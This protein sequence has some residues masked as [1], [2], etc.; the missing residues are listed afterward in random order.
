M[1]RHVVGFS[2]V[3]S[4][5]GRFTGGSREGS[6]ALSGPWNAKP[7]AASK[8]AGLSVTRAR[9][10]QSSPTLPRSS[11]FTDRPQTRVTHTTRKSLV[12][13]VAGTWYS[14]KAGLGSEMSTSSSEIV[15]L[16]SA[17]GATGVAALGTAVI[18][19][20]AGVSCV[21]SSMGLLS[22]VAVGS[23]ATGTL[24][25][26]TSM[27]GGVWPDCV[28]GDAYRGGERHNVLVSEP[29][30]GNRSSSRDHAR[31]LLHPHNYRV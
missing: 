17:K 10:G 19:A 8:S 5:H 21:G 16:V 20:I 7:S 1:K 13:V 9:T 25:D 27:V 18:V 6:T 15:S 22:G 14:G 31:T 4:A 26:A 28:A 11:S 3:S 30:A 12:F 23:P 2:C 29:R 24:V